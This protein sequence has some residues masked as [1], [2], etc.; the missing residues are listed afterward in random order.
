MITYE[1][2]VD[3]MLLRLPELKEADTLG[4]IG[5]EGNYIVF[6][7]LL[8]PWLE[9]A[10]IRGDL[11]RILRT[12]AFLEEVSENATNDRRLYDLIGIA[13]GEWLPNLLYEDRLA[14]WLGK[15][16]K[17]ICDYVPGLATQRRADML[18]SSRPRLS[19]RLRAIANRL[20]KR[21]KEC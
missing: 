4:Y 18:R 10:L 1:N 14:P 21:N 15:E 12:T 13:I 20:M 11:A 3:E 19:H 17:R 9:D 16:T 2:V 8:V 6:E 7:G 5:E